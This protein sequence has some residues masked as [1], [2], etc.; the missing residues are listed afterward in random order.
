[1]NNRK[2]LL[3]IVAAVAALSVL[4]GCV[5]AQTAAN[6][7]TA[8]QACAVGNLPYCNLVPIYEAQAQQE[9]NESGLAFGAGLLAITAGIA[10][11]VS[12]N[13]CCYY[14]RGWGRW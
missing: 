4:T 6:L 10:V 5:S 13:N 7:S 12:N 9:K 14:R 8:R 2:R 3:R 1:M 11:G